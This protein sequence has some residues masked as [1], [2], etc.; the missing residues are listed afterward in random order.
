MRGAIAVIITAALTFG[1]L[2]WYWDTGREHDMARDE[3]LRFCQQLSSGLQRN[4]IRGLLEGRQYSHLTLA[5]VDENRWLV[6]TPYSFG[7]KN[8]VLWLEFQD[9]ALASARV[10]VTDSPDMTPPGAP[11][12]RY[13]SRPANVE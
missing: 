13:F 4:D 11:P 12:D 10:R 6:S 2:M 3:L 8:W 1:G 9:S 5:V 7:A